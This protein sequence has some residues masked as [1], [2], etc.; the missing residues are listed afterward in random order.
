MSSLLLCRGV[1]AAAVRGGRRQPAGTRASFSVAAASSAPPLAVAVAGRS[2]S[3]AAAAAAAARTSANTAAI[4]NN[5]TKRTSLIG[6][7][8]NA[9]CDSLEKRPLITKA[10]MAAVIFFSSDSVTQYLLH[11]RTALSNDSFFAWDAARAVSAGNF[12]V[13]S[14]TFLHFWW[15][16]LER[17]VGAR[18]P[19]A[20]HKLA[21]TAAKVFLHQSMGA[22]FYI[23]S[24]YVLTNFGQ[25]V[26][27]V[28]GLDGFTQAWTDVNEKAAHML[29]PTMLRHW[30]VWPFVQSVNFYYT[31]LRHRVLVHNSVLTLWSGYL[32]YLNH[33]HSHTP[34]TAAT[35][36]PA[37]EIE[38]AAATAPRRRNTLQRA[39]EERLEKVKNS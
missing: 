7:L 1:T 33:N 3:S 12:G 9:Y 21:N 27:T 28:E 38:A 24:Y 8:W 31:P 36:P 19:L 10:S 13:I 32:S 25:R 34:A 29:L 23:Y 37:G 35:P 14:T 6:N 5:N 20:T 17:G 4:I 26:H 18:I 11:D 30:S 2:S 22:P 15:A 39:E 16:L